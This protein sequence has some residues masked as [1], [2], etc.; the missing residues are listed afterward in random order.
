LSGSFLSMSP[1]RITEKNHF[2][3]S[4]LRSWQPSASM[5]REAMVHSELPV[6]FRRFYRTENKL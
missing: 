4:P 1:T 5:R 6:R 3:T 2:A